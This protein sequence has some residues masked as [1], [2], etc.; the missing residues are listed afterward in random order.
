MLG[1]RFN[2]YDKAREDYIN[3]LVS[4]A[5]ETLRKSKSSL[6]IILDAANGAA[7]LVAGEVF[8]KLGFKVIEI[9][10]KPNGVNINKDAGSTDP[11]FL[12]TEIVR[13]KADIGFAYDGDADRLIC[14]DEKANIIDG[15]IMLFILAK[16]LRKKGELEN[17]CVA[18]TVMS[19]LGLIKAFEAQGIDVDITDVGDRYVLECMQKK[20]YSLGGEQSGHIIFL[21][22][23]T[24]GDGIYASLKMLAA[25]IHKGKPLSELASDVKIYPQVI[26][27]AKV[28]NEKKKAFAN[29]NEITSAI[30]N[31]ETRYQGNGRVLIRP[32]GTEPM[33]RVMIEGDD[34]EKIYEDAKKIAEMIASKYA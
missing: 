31:L 1:R 20:G 11:K 24:T 6:K 21:D 34:E 4:S 16:M 5:D 28:R 22:K 17:N 25:I 29:D 2:I 15:D 27:N 26:V 10:D 3:F 7:S 12:A 18:V 13:T 23:N 33:V 30:K 14:V 8:R 19:N 32:S 9:N